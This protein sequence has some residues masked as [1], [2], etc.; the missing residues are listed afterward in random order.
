MSASLLVLSV[1][2]C[3]L[4]DT[5]PPRW[6][7]LSVS[8]AACYQR[9]QRRQNKTPRGPHDLQFHKTEPLSNRNLSGPLTKT[10]Q[11]SLHPE[12]NICAFILAL[13]E[14]FLISFFLLA[15]MAF[16]SQMNSETTMNSRAFSYKH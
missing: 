15:H 8:L 12:Q 14:L 4:I 16:R 6:A 2:S 9:Y 13:C 11:S 10:T 3:S 5:S 1:I 7:D